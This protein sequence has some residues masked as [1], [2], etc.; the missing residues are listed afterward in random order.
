MKIALDL[1]GVLADQH[2]QTLR[3]SDRLTVEDFE[4][5]E[6]PDTDLFQHF[7]GVS[8]HVWRDKWEDI[9]PSQYDIARFTEE[10]NDI[11]EVHIVTNRSGA[12]EQIQK[13]LDKHGIVYEEFFSNPNKTKK[14]EMDYDVYIDDNPGMWGDVDLLYVPTKP[15]NNQYNDQNP[16]ED[17]G[18]FIYREAPNWRI[19]SERP[20][21]VRVNNLNQILTHL[22][23]I[24][25]VEG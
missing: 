20:L 25:D 12:D 17:S 19:P 16:P 4:K 13:W 1:E 18:N 10:L 2:Y 3:N 24:D 14:S 9:S 8:L 11:G 22:R 6:F 21:V 23:K 5:W 7:M 15:W